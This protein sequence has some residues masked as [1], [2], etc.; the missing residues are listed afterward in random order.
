MGSRP[1]WAG[2]TPAP[3]IRNGCGTSSL[4]GSYFGPFTTAASELGSFPTSPSGEVDV[5]LR[6]SGEGA[7]I[8]RNAGALTR[9]GGASSPGGVCAWDMGNRCAGT[10]VTPKRHA[11]PPAGGE[12]DAMAGGYPSVVAR[13]VCAVG[14]TGRE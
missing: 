3:G 10:W 12:Q 7:S 4:S 11:E 14:W 2:V 5:S 6:T 13:G 9:A 8:E 1:P